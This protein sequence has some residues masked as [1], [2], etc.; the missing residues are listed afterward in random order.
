MGAMTSKA[1]EG[2]EKPVSL[3]D[4]A[5]ERIK[6]LI[7]QLQFKPG[8]QLQIEEL[9][10]MLGVS[11]TPIREA[12]LRLE[13]DGLMRI[14]PRVGMFVTDITSADLEELYELRELL[15]SRAVERAVQNLSDDDLD[16]LDR[17]LEGG[18]GAAESGDV[19]GFLRAEIEFHS[20]LL[21]HSGNR[22]MIVTM[23]SFRD[24]TYRWRVLSV[25]AQESLFETLAEPRKIAQALRLREAGLAGRLM[26][27]HIQAAKG[28]IQ[29]VV[30][31]K[32]EVGSPEAR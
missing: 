25:R 9:T 19:D 4:W 7:L 2:W 21:D 20:F 32:E 24:L 28:R 31:Q 26:K 23:E 10:E 29:H 3:A 11:R 6:G 13:R 12:I 5:Y 1:S 14:V 27:E 18:A 15:E 8:Q 16:H 30:E 22:R 17:V